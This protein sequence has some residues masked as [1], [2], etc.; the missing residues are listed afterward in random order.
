MAAAVIGLAPILPVIAD[1]CELVIPALLLLL[2]LQ[3]EVM[4]AIRINTSPMVR[5]LYFEDRVS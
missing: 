3:P 1:V 2:L 4:A 5:L